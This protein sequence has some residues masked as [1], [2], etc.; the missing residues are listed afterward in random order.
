MENFHTSRP[1]TI[2]ILVTKAYFSILFLSN[3]G[4]MIPLNP[5]RNVWPTVVFFCRSIRNPTSCRLLYSIPSYL[6]ER[7][8]FFF[9]DCSKRCMICTD[10]EQLQLIESEMK[11]WSKLK[12]NVFTYHSPK[13]AATRPI[14]YSKKQCINEKFLFFMKLCINHPQIIPK[15]HAKLEKNCCTS[16]WEK[17]SQDTE[18]HSFI[19]IRINVL[20]KLF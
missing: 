17:V 4:R 11:S 3:Q 5:S 8:S 9:L 15:H 20:P 2:F 18:G 7:N 19:I 12:E 10:L 14:F 6:E 13:R 1:S 16:S